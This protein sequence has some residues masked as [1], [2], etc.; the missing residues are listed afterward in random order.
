MASGDT[1]VFYVIPDTL[2]RLRVEASAVDEFGN[3]QQLQRIINVINPLRININ[4]ATQPFDVVLPGVGETWFAL[5]RSLYDRNGVKLV[6]MESAITAMTHL[7][8]RMLLALQDIGLVIVDPLN[9]YTVLGTHLTA[10]VISQVVHIDDQVIAVIDGVAVA[11]KVT[12][13]ALERIGN[14][15]VSGRT[16]DVQVLATGFVVLTDQEIVSL[17]TDRLVQKRHLGTFTAMTRHGGALYVVSSSGDLLVFDSK[18][19]A[20]VIKLGLTRNA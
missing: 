9:T 17:S 15:S 1:S 8:D 7:G 4:P 19:N 3:S 20:K 11:F 5:D 10:G 12:G 16:I 14:L 6:T 2:S 13:N 18:F